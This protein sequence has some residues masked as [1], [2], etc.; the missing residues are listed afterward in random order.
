MYML[1]R[2]HIENQ[3]NKTCSK[4]EIWEGTVGNR[5]NIFSLHMIYLD[6]IMLYNMGI[7]IKGNSQS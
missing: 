1:K 2:S 5:H 4:K 3:L 6:Y 7:T